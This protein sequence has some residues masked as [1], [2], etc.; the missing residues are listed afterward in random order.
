[1]IFTDEMNNEPGLTTRKKNPLLRMP[2]I[3]HNGHIR[4]MWPL[5]SSVTQKPRHSLVVGSYT[6]REPENHQISPTT[7]TRRNRQE[8]SSPPS[9]RE[10][11][12]FLKNIFCRQLYYNE[13]NLIISKCSVFIYTISIQLYYKL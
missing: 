8:K 1:M 12:Q 10:I 6:Q 7:Q 11:G 5:P 3:Q 2:P 4:T 9:L 13:V